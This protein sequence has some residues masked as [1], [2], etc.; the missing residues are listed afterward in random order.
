[1]PDDPTR[2]DEWPATGPAH[3]CI[4]CGAF[5]DDLIQRRGA[6]WH[7]D[8]CSRSWWATNYQDRRFLRVLKIAPED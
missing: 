8:C 5:G 1:M 2:P 6:E 4:Y 7:C 3:A